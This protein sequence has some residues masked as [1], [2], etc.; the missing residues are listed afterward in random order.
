MVVVLP[1]PPA[2]AQIA[3]S[4]D[5]FAIRPLRVTNSSDTFGLVPAMGL[6]RFSG[7]PI[8][9][10]TPPG[11]FML[12]FGNLDLNRCP[13]CRW[14]AFNLRRFECSKWKNRAKS[15]P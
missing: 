3:M 12:A 4:R 11:F 10:A 5:Q 9:A 8:F 6:E 14:M 15:H 13:P 1:S 7:M 2:S